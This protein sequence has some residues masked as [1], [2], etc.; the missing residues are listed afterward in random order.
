[1]SEGRPC[2]SAMSG[3]KPA[4]VLSKQFAPKAETDPVYALEYFPVKA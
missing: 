4:Y 3:R 1:M 2:G